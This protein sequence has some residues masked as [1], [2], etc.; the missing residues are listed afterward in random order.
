M[1]FITRR[2]KLI[3]ATRGALAP[4]AK[5]FETLFITCQCKHVVFRQ[6]DSRAHPAIHRWWAR[7]RSMRDQSMDQGGIL[8]FRTLITEVIL[9]SSFE[10]FLTTQSENH[11]KK[12]ALCLNTCR[13]TGFFGILQDETCIQC[14]GERQRSQIHRMGSHLQRDRS[15]VQLHWLLSDGH[16]VRNSPDLTV[17]RTK[18]ET[19]QESLS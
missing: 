9:R 11:G 5:W 18:R 2:A 8:A 10:V 17:R 7:D 19:I 4:N 13:W 3:P 12:I 6:P 1:A 14:T 15:L 16:D